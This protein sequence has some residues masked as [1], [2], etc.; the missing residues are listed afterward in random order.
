ML[1]WLALVTV[2]FD[3]FPWGFASNG[4]PWGLSAREWLPNVF[5]IVAGAII[6]MD[7]LKHRVRWYVVAAG[8]LVG[9]TLVKWP[10]N[11]EIIR[12]LLPTWII[13][14]ALV[15]I[16]IW[17]AVDPLLRIHSTNFKCDAHQRIGA[18]N[19]LRQKLMFFQNRSESA[20]HL[21]RVTRD[22]A[23]NVAFEFDIVTG[24]V[25]RHPHAATRT[26]C[27]DHPRQSHVAGVTRR[28]YLTGSSLTNAPLGVAG[29]RF[30]SH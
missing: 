12:Q 1:T 9:A 26:F 25:N 14:L 5:L 8:T 3:P 13:Q 24:T 23:D 19:A 2:F 18:R 30:L 4:Q 27:R 20:A 16:A 29:P 28:H 17:L 10:W 7:L 21:S 15:P 11:H 6:L 22:L